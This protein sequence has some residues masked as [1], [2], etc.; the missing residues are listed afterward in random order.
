VVW[1]DVAVLGEFVVADRA[2]AAL[3][4]D[5]PVQQLPHL[6]GRP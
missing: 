3:L 5:F 4:D 6:S 2:F 1:D